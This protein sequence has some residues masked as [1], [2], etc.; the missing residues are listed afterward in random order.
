MAQEQLLN[1]DRA[2][3]FARLEVLK[4]AQEGED[5]A[6]GKAPVRTG[7][8]KASIRAKKLN[9]PAERKWIASAALRARAFPGRFIE[10][11][12]K[13]MAAKPFLDPAIP[14]AHKIA[15]RVAEA[16]AKGL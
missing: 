5:P 14:E 7:R 9:H 2:F 10:R 12:T 3:S 1:V 15:R 4:I 13:G 11:G 6:K 16:F 8:L